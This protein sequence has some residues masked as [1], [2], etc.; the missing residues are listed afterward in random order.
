M[1]KK[2]LISA[3]A[4]CQDCDWEDEDYNTAQKEARRHAMQTGHMV[5]IETVYSQVYNQEKENK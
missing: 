3:L 2:R 4:R 1:I 5:V